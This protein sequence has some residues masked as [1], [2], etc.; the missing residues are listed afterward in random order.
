VSDLVADLAN[1]L[2][3]ISA[4]RRR[5]IIPR[6][7]KNYTFSFTDIARTS[8][9]YSVKTLNEARNRIQVAM[10]E[11]KSQIASYSIQK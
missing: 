11:A 7:I 5:E 4:K 3:C 9:N 8:N 6:T 1:N 2:S 10:G